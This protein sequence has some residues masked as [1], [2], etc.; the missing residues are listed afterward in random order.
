M[1]E[2]AATTLVGA[3][4]VPW[5]LPVRLALRYRGPHEFHYVLFKVLL[6]P[7]YRATISALHGSVLPLLDIGCGP[8]LLACYLRRCGFSGAIHGFDYDARKIEIARR[9]TE[10][11]PN[12]QFDTGDARTSLPPHHGHVTIL[13]ILQFFTPTEQEALLRE[14]AARVAPGGRLIIRS[15]LKDEGWRFGVTRAGDWFAKV[16]AWMKEHPVHYPTEGQLR[17]VLEG[18]GLRGAVTPLPGRLPFNNFLLVFERPAADV[19]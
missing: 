11:L 13:D 3:P 16:T 10:S 6:D 8:G 9:A 17:A 19:A 12:C 7:V 14:A 1:T 4:A 15:C 2:M 18:A 5:G